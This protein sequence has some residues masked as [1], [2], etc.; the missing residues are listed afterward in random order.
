MSSGIFQFASYESNV[1]TLVF[2][3]RVQPE[4]IEAWNPDGGAITNG[5]PSVKVR[6][7]KREFGIFC[8]RVTGTWVTA[9]AGYQAGGS[10]TV[11]V[12]TKAA[13]EA[14]VKGAV[15]GY[16]GGTFRVVGII[17]EQVR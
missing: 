5:L 3:C 9:P 16:L 13:F 4:T 14:I 12:F 2:P 6:G 1:A 11:P 7:G 15:L 17:P 10:V 8:R